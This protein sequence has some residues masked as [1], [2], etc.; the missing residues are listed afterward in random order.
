MILIRDTMTHITVMIKKFLKQ[1]P[2]VLKRCKTKKPLLVT[3]FSLFQKLMIF[4]IKTITVRVNS[5]QMKTGFFFVNL[6]LI[7]DTEL[8]I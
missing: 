8:N 6:E 4:P 2:S 3:F 1:R 7:T 5:T